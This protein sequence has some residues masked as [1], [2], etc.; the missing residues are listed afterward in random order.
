[1][2]NKMLEKLVNEYSPAL[3]RVAFSK[4]GDSELSKD[5]AQ[6][7]FL[8]LYEKQPHF[9]SRDQLKVWLIRVTCKLAASEKRRFDYS[10]TVPLEKASDRVKSDELLFEFADLLREL[11]ESL[12]LVTVLFYIEDMSVSDISET[13]GISKGSVKTRLSRA[14][15][16]LEILYKEGLV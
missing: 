7:A 16:R 12:R 10:H 14:R 11:P 2:D 6:Q 5:I 1:M 13:L 8:L 4:T 3:Y 9:D 15:D